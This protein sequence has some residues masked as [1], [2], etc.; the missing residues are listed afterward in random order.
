MPS[1]IGIN[2]GHDSS[3][4]LVGEEGNVIFAI[5]EERLNRSKGYRG[6]P[7]KALSSIGKEIS[8]QDM[9]IER[10]VIGTTNQP[11]QSFAD[12]LSTRLN[13]D[14]LSGNEN[15]SEQYFNRIGPG[16]RL[17]RNNSLS[18]QLEIEALIL[19][20]LAQGGIDKS[21]LGSNSF[22]WI[23]H[24]DA[25]LGCG[26]S[27]A[28]VD[29][30]T[31]L[32]SMDGDGDGE[33]GAVALLHKGT[34]SQRET[35]SGS[36]DSLGHL[37]SCVTQAYGFKASR[38]EGK[39]TGLAAFGKYSEAVEILSSAIQIE[40]GKIS[41]RTLKKNALAKIVRRLKT[42]GIA[43]NV[44]TDMMEIVY[45]A[46]KVTN[47][48]PDLAFAIQFV[49]EDAIR[50]IT[51]YWMNKFECENL[52][53][54]GGVF[55][56]V[57]LNQKLA[58]LSCVDDIR[59]FPNMGDGGLSCGGVWSSMLKR[60]MPIEAPFSNVFLGNNTKQDEITYPRGIEK[61][62][63]SDRDKVDCAVQTIL[64]GGYCGIH[65]GR[66]EFGP[67]A[68][69]HR[70]IVFDPRYREL[71]NELNRRLKRTEFM[72]FAPAIL[73]HCLDDWMEPLPSCTNAFE[74]M[75]IT[76]KVKQERQSMIEA[77]VHEDGTARPQ[78]VTRR[79]NQ[80][81]YE[82]LNRFNECSGIPILVNTS[83]N[84]HE[85]PINYKIEDSLKSLQM[86]IVDIIVTDT[87]I[88]KIGNP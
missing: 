79:S 36:L 54:T 6:I 27:M 46:E 38:H 28:K 22:E 62:E 83:F 49:I 67:R 19:E 9:D 59:I 55:S 15:G 75:T 41:L 43:R 24:H 4:S 81:L 61:I 20:V 8:I 37:Y 51:A 35:I 50:E 30:P 1:I 12:E 52:V 31:L 64:S 68:L 32:L 39:I 57:K 42:V 23:K 69:G 44:Y 82:L 45:E 14:F 87:G 25:H 29:E 21:F 33:S 78:I 18:P 40:S 72:P 56:N 3:A 17:K 10:V 58:E 73:D 77:V 76:C 11:N 74:F 60:G 34:I 5:E 66:M 71:G 63:L 84:I 26:I 7:A 47:A 48:F 53:L 88:L 16:N 13:N 65:L 80:F 70:S 85:E 2:L 86:G